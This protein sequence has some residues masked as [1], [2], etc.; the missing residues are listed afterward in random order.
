MQTGSQRF[1]INYKYLQNNFKTRIDLKMKSLFLIAFL[2]IFLSLKSTD[3][4]N[5]VSNLISTIKIVTRLCYFPH[6][7]SEKVA[8]GF[9]GCYDYAPVS[10]ILYSIFLFPIFKKQDTFIGKMAIL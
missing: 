6:V 7:N 1:L 9:I 2:F 5:V 4:Q 10:S 8:K 3:S